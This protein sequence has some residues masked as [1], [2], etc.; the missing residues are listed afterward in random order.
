M[1]PA[2]NQLPAAPPSPPASPAQRKALALQRIDASRTQLI[3]CLLPPEPQKQSATAGATGSPDFLGF[4]TT[5]MNRIERNGLVNGGW[6][7]LRAWGRRWWT[8][9]PW[10]APVEL[11][12]TTVAHEA[13]PIIRRHPWATLAVGAAVG[14]SLV[15]AL[16]WAGSRIRQ[17]A[18]PWR[19]H[20]GSLVWGQLAQASV[21][22][23]LAGAVTAWLSGLTRQSTSDPAD[24][25]APAD[26]LSQP[27]SPSPTDA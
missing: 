13:K 2:P 27:P 21:Q 8:R 16:P 15:A 24:G 26:P 12:V 7:M 10:H 14:A 25:A 3:L 4:A 20:L 18:R 17:Q 19:N 1:N 11:V 23:A 5:L 6:R 22:M 9:Q